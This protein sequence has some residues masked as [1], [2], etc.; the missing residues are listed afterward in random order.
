MVA[1]ERVFLT[2]F[3]WET[4]RLFTKWSFTGGGRLREVVAR[5]ELTVFPSLLCCRTCHSQ[6]RS[7]RDISLLRR[8]GFPFFPGLI[9]K[10]NV[11]DKRRKLGKSIQSRR[12]KKSALKLIIF[13]SL[14]QFLVG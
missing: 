11:V 10:Q 12:L 7:K 14:L 8:L 6:H 13:Y 4:K 9:S 2:V 1:Y 3:D 5:R